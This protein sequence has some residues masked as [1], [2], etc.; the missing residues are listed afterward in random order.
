MALSSSLRILLLSGI[1]LLTWIAV[2]NTPAQSETA[3][4]V[5]EKSV[6]N[7]YVIHKNILYK[8]EQKKLV[9][10]SSLE[11]DPYLS[12]DDY[13]VTLSE[14]IHS[15]AA[16]LPGKGTYNHGKAINIHKIEKENK[17]KLYRKIDL[18]TDYTVKTTALYKGILFVTGNLGENIFGFYDTRS[19]RPQFVP[20]RVPAEVKQ[21]MFDD[22]IVDG[23]TLLAVDNVVWPKWL[24]LFDISRPKDPKTLK[25]V[26]LMEGVNE[27]IEKGVVG[28]NY[29]VLFAENSTKGGRRQA[30]QIY[31]KSENYKPLSE[32][33][34]WR[35]SRQSEEETGQH[36][37]PVMSFMDDIFILSGYG[38]GVGVIDCSSK[39]TDKSVL[40]PLLYTNEKK[41]SVPVVEAVVLPNNMIA[42]KTEKTAEFFI[43][44]KNSLSGW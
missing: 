2:G 22:L 34:L 44:N 27:H 23:N 33:T 31:S 7:N 37:T 29:L 16:S 36:S 40:K 17:L 41:R 11:Y 32:I 25:V 8:I 20:L 4:N 21:K 35:W 3:V 1:C 30:L 12:S 18:P 28:N 42:I 10:I 9:Q 24:V 15:G 19:E 26:E 39:I 5:A 14:T 6:S 13:I 43:V 38:P